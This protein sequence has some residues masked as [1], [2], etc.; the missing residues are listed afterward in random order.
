VLLAYIDLL[1][2]HLTMSLHTGAFS[3]LIIKMTVYSSEAQYHK[4]G[5]CPRLQSPR[6]A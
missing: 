6:V 1:D 5:S 4:S 2:D 3:T